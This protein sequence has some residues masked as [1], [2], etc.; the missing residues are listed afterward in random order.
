S[1]SAREELLAKR[2]RRR[3]P[4]EAR[5]RLLRNVRLDLDARPVTEGGRIDRIRDLVEP[6]AAADCQHERAAPARADD[7]MRR[8]AR[9]VHVV[10]LRER[11]LCALDDQQALAAQHEKAFLIALAVVHR[12]RLPRCKRGE[13]DAELVEVLRPVELRRRTELVL[14]PLQLAH[15]S[16]EPAHERNSSRNATSVLAPNS[17]YAARASCVSSVEAR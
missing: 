8:A 16:Y 1:S 12:H 15:I 5:V 3:R 6:H 10:P 13:V 14:L 9:R 17:A 11:Y 7:R 4:R 2:H